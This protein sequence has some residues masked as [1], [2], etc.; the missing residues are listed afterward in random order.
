M[1]LVMGKTTRSVH[2]RYDRMVAASVLNDVIFHMRTLCLHFRT[3]KHDRASAAA[4]KA[5]RHEINLRDFTHNLQLLDQ[6][7]RL[8]LHLTSP[9]RH[10]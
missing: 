2:E 1:N 10:R 5:M 6:R 9:I 7:S 4:N 8:S 3:G